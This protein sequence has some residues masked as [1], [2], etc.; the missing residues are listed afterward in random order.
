MTASN[1]NVFFILCTAG[2]ENVFFSPQDQTVR[3]G[4]GVFLQCV[5]GES[6]PPASITWLKDGA[7]VTRGRQI[8]VNTLPPLDW[9]LPHH[10]WEVKSD[11]AW[12]ALQQQT[13]SL[14]NTSEIPLKSLHLMIW[15]IF[16]VQS[17][18]L[19]CCCQ[20][21]LQITPSFKQLEESDA[22]E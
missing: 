21:H 8:Q 12:G 3:E 20:L 9:S 4:E 18:R 1:I 7:L 11:F 2:L 10:L 22:A 19:P 13:S 16:V 6:S 5:S 15:V 17:S 14:S